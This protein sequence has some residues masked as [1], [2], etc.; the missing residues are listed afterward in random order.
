MQAKKRTQKAKM[1]KSGKDQRPYLKT[2]SGKCLIALLLFCILLSMLSRFPAFIEHYYALGLYPVIAGGLRISFGW[3]PFSLGD[4]LYTLLGIFMLWR[5]IRF[6]RILVKRRW[7]KPYGFKS[8]Y[9]VLWTGGI[10]YALFYLFWGLNYS[11]LGIANQLGLSVTKDYNT[12]ELQS[13][14]QNLLKK[15]NQDRRRLG[16]PIELPNAKTLFNGAVQAYQQIDKKYSFLAYRHRSIKVP[17]YNALGGYLQYTGYYNPFT[18]EAQVNTALP[19]IL[20]PYVTCH[21]MA[22]QLGYAS[23][24]E[25]NFVGFL[26]AT[27]SPDPLFQYSTHLELFRYANSELWYRDSNMARSNYKQLDTLV[28]QDLTHLQAFF[29]AH[30]NPIGRFTT[31]IYGLFLK[32]NQQPQGLDTYDQVTAW[33]LAYQKKFKK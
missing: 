25:A 23:E 2:R 8:L 12:E 15:T 24:D 17:I 13:L 32:A 29:E 27:A 7:S 19:G 11:R 9:T 14:T 22:H 5:L 1:R 3:L 10:I 30:E 4:L 18:G 16:S 31:K 26:A 21:E 33:L 28:K 6:I 20:L